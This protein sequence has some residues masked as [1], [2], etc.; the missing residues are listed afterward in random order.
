MQLETSR[1]I[2][3]PFT[4]NDLQSIHLILDQE[5]KNSDFGNE[6][7]QTL[8]ER[9]RWLQWTLLSYEQFSKLN[10]PPYGERAIVHKDSNKLIGICG[11]VPCLDCFEQLCD[12]HQDERPASQSLST[13]EFGLFYAISKSSQ[14]FGFATEAAAALATYAFEQL[15]V[16]RIIATTTYDNLASIK[17]MRKLG[18]NFKKN[19]LS[20]PPWLQLVGILNNPAKTDPGV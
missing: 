15:H 6:G 17:V 1:L 2:I 20:L 3:R 8:S 18:M 13:T 5:L 12:L 4:L 16:K 7:A 14:G 9:E 10:Q 11:Y 19:S